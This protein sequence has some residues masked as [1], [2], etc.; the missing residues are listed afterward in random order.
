MSS[1]ACR[2]QFP[3]GSSVPGCVTFKAGKAP[4]LHVAKLCFSASHKALARGREKGKCTNLAPIVVLR[5]RLALPPWPRAADCRGGPRVVTF[6]I[7]RNAR[8]RGGGPHWPPRATCVPRLSPPA[9]ASC[10]CCSLPGSRQPCSPAPPCARLTGRRLLLPLDPRR[11]EPA[12]PGVT[13][14]P[15]RGCWGSCPC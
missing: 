13:R 5:V 2:T 7:P 10:L 12:S 9:Q 15:S 6:Q 4:G 1:A 8:G 3:S 14:G 11:G